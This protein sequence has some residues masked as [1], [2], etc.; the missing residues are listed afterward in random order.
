MVPLIGQMTPALLTLIRGLSQVGVVTWLT[1][2]LE[3]RFAYA[4]QE[5][6]RHPGAKIQHYDGWTWVSAWLQGLDDGYDIL[7]AVDR[8]ASI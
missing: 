4:L 3:M 7:S 1:A 6:S 5:V 8:S 2:A